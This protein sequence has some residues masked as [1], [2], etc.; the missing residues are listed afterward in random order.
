MKTKIISVIAILLLISGTKS[1][2]GDPVNVPKKVLVSFE[3]SFPEIQK[4][5]WHKIKDFYEVSFY[6]SPKK[7][8]CRIFY[9]PEGVILETFKNYQ[10]E[11]LPLFIRVNL[12]KEYPGK[13]II[14]ITE[15]YFEEETHYYILLQD[16]HRI[17]KV[18]SNEYGDLYLEKS[19]NRAN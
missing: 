14:D 3:N 19:F 18:T 6:E 13:K 8:S 10:E 12:G 15:V 1:F 7:M 2:A 17:Y 5:T 4:E 16:E 11:G 9:S